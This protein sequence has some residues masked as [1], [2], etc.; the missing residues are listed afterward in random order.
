MAK[1]VHQRFTKIICTLGPSTDSYKKIKELVS[2]GMNVAR[3]NFSHGKHKDHK[4]KMDLIR[5]ISKETGKPVAIL[6]DLQGPKI[7]VQEFENGE[8]FLKDGSSFCLT[9]R[10]I[11]GND[12]EVSVSYKR[13]HLDL[14]P[15][16]T[17]LLDDG[18]LKLKVTKV[19]GKDVHCKV[20]YGGP[21]K[22][23]KG[24]NLPGTLLK[25]DALTDKDEKDLL[26]G[27][28]NG[29]DYVA[30]S[31]VQ[32]PADIIKIKKKI[33]DFGAKTPVIAKIEKP[34]AVDVI[35]DI[36]DLADGI[37]IAR[38]DLGVEMATEEV[39][40]I[41]KEIIAE[42]NIRGKPVITATQMLESMIIHPR[43]TRAE[44][45]DVANAV[46]DGTDAV[47]LS[48]ET[49]SGAYPV[50]A[51]KMMN[52]IIKLI[53]KTGRDKDRKISLK[54]RKPDHIYDEGEAIGYSA[55][56][57]AELVNA[58]IIVCLT[59][60]GFSANMISRFRPDI[61]ILAITP[62]NEAFY[63]SALV[64]GVAGLKVKEFADNFD[65]SVIEIIDIL[66]KKKIIKKGEKI[67]LTAGA[68][69]DM[70]LQTN[71]LRIETIK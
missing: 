8:I 65:M 54:R 27:L 25:I 41:Q 10:D 18:N 45:T 40:P 37:M 17:V 38:G 49:A 5:K 69:F 66:K 9:T 60:S 4:E 62:N 44:A 55:T 67:I 28:K 50:E 46:L 2:A 35:E 29:V 71:T 39:P 42:C 59:Q 36:I 47:M 19:T 13:L 3:L 7:R 61:P 23:H 51:V 11:T 34:Q 30:L 52:K 26:F 6:Q 14:K 68:P 12:K 16:D 22:D 31:F 15:R 58:T 1:L 33:K 43:P 64:W 21:L 56:H 24:L 32:K 57:A 20:I 70:K 48:G 63:K 53:E